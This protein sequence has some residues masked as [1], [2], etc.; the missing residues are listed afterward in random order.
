MSLD[1]DQVEVLL[2]GIKPSRVS[3]TQGQKYLESFDVIAHL[4]RIFGFGGWDSETVKGPDLIFEAER[5][6]G[7][8][9]DL[10]HTGKW[11]VAYKATVRITIRDRAGNIVCHHEGSATGDGQNQNRVDAH[12]L[13]L[14]S[15]ESTAEKRAARKL[16]DQMGLS[17]YDKGSLEPTV[18]RL[19]SGERAS[20]DDREP[21]DDTRNGSGQDQPRPTGA[22]SPRGASAPPAPDDEPFP[23]DP[24]GPSPT[25]VMSEPARK[26]IYALCKKLGLD[27][28]GFA[29]ATLG[30]TVEHLSTLPYA[31]GKTI[32][33]ALT[34]L[35]KKKGAARAS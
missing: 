21:A 14:K 2:R 5:T 13:A 32:N 3:E 24:E 26:R 11:D 18:K 25:N 28:L 30:R 15:A 10:R 6:T 8:A 27:P 35:E 33:D 34:E 19:V 22:A 31:D 20:D 4:I 23:D 9:E 16:G 29:A 17:L 12:D 7:P 1:A